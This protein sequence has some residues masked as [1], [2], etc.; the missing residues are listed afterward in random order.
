MS[1]NLSFSKDL[2]QI[3]MSN[4][5]FICLPK[6][7]TKKERERETKVA[8]LSIDIITWVGVLV[9]ISR[10]MEKKNWE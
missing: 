2:F 7:K 1:L 3:Q 6:P 4:N 9:K 10:M 5:C 8:L